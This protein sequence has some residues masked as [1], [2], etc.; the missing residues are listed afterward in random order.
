M[1]RL[2]R[3]TPIPSS[4]YHSNFGNLTIYPR[5]LLHE[6]QDTSVVFEM[7]VRTGTGSTVNG[8]GYTSVGPNISFWRNVTGGWVVRG[9]VGT[10]IPTGNDTLGVRTTADAFFSVG[11]YITPHDALPIG[12]FV[13]YLSRR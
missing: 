7:P 12:D 11:N 4:G 13:Y 10:T 6:T 1:C 2:S 5:V 9:G 3:R 8:N